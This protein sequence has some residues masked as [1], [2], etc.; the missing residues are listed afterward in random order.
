M[1]ALALIVVLGLFGV[2]IAMV[3]VPMAERSQ[4]KKGKYG[5]FQVDFE[6]TL[7]QTF[8]ALDR[9]QNSLFFINASIPEYNGRE[10]IVGYRRA[11]FKCSVTDIE[12]VQI[13]KDEKETYS[14]GF[15]FQKEVPPG[16]K[17][18][19]LSFNMVYPKDAE[20]LKYE[21]HHLVQ[22]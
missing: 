11:K 17:W 2:L 3:A 4:L 14:V 8:V 9:K 18:K 5:P 10:Q 22:E 20:A 12:S 6:V 13:K 16:N 1:S 19:A 21:L 7:F 15:T